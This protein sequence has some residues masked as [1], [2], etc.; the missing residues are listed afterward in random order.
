MVLAIQIIK[1]LI[2]AF[3]IVIISKY[4][5]AWTLRKIGDTLNLKSSTIGT[6]TGVATSTPELLSTCFTA[7]VGLISTS[8]Y[9]ILSSNIINIFLYLFSVIINK[10]IKFLKNKVIIIDIVMAI[11][12]ITIP[13]FL[14]IN[15]I[16]MSFTIVPTFILLFIL[17]TMIN[18]YTHESFF[19]RKDRSLIRFFR[20]FQKKNLKVIQ[21]FFLLALILFT[22]FI[23]A[24]L[25]TD[26]LK[27][28]CITFK[29]P[30]LIMGALL[31][32]ISSIPELITFIESQRFYDKENAYDGVVEATNNLFTSNV[33]NLF[34]IQTI[35]IVLFIICN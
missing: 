7:T 25:L 24:D 3:L 18:S 6:L 29:V 5:L 32:I 1:F 33:M 21:Y 14:V 30:E 35:A 13:L 2:F 4:A 23:C 10:N 26:S 28:I 12:T 27:V 16:E 11:I 19:K 17:F 22:L 20:R 8:I 9:N 34:V 31:G 15:D